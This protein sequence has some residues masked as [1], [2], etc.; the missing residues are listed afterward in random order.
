MIDI[1][2]YNLK[3]HIKLTGKDNKTVLDNVKYLGKINKL[4]EIRTVIVP[5]ILDNYFKFL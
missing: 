2:S 1:K 4:Y 3:E 5:E